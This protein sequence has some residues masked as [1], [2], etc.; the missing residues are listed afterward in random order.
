MEQRAKPI[1]LRRVGRAQDI[2]GAVAFL[3]GPDGVYVNGVD[4]TVDGGQRLITMDAA[5]PRDRDY[6]GDRGG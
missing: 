1:P 4:L 2:A 3:A 5:L 6:T